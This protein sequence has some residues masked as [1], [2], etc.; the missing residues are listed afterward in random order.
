MN[1]KQKPIKSVNELIRALDI[2]TQ[3]SQ[4]GF[5]WPSWHGALDKVREE[6]DEVYD[7]LKQYPQDKQKIDEELGDLLF[8]VVN[9]VRHHKACPNT[10]LKSASDKFEGRY[11]D[12][13]YYVTQLGLSMEQ[14][15]DEEMEAGWQYAKA[16]AKKR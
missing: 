16:Q 13:E 11:Q 3:V 12:V 10:L 7:E 4:A 15:T 1:D 9:V 14:A 8:A 2:Q 6:V 5:D